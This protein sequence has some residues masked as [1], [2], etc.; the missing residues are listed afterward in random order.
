LSRKLLICPYFGDLP[1]WWP[2]YYREEIPRLRREGFDMHVNLN[3]FDFHMR[4]MEILGI[5]P[6]HMTGTGKI[7]DFRPALGLLYAEELK[8]YDWWGHT[9]FDCVYGRVSAF[10]L[11]EILDGCDIYSDCAHGY[12]AGPW[13]LYRNVKEVNHLFFD[14]EW[15]QNMLSPKPTAWV[16]TSYTD[17]AQASVRVNIGRSHRWLLPGMLRRDGDRLLHSDVEI[18]MFHFRRTKEWPL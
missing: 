1:P 8:G 15:E 17:L 18:P 16:E 10:S 3:E 11:D 14:G 12:L 13:T 5:D 6:P 9:D 4:C 7:W 2:L